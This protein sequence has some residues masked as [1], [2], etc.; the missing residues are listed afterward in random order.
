MRKSEEERFW[1]KVDRSGDGCW[2]WTAKSRT[3]FGYGVMRVGG[4]P[5]RLEGAH[6]LAWQYTNGP[7]PDGLCVLHSC[8]NPPCCNPA[9][10]RIGTKADNTRDKVERGRA[11][12]WKSG[13]WKTCGKGHD[14]WHYPKSGKPRYCRTCAREAQ[15]EWVKKNPTYH[16]DYTRKRRAKP[17][18]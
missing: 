11:V 16:R 18:E 4:T 2:E 13:P 14:D 12:T 8:D 15:V 5:G 10:L 6:R 9:H 7:I 3:S 17:K 1:S